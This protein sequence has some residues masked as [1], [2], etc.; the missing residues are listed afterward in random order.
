MAKLCDACDSTLTRVFHAHSQVTADEYQCAV[1]FRHYIGDECQNED[2]INTINNQVY[3]PSIPGVPIQRALVFDKHS[4]NWVRLEADITTP[5]TEVDFAHSCF[6]FLANEL[7]RY[8]AFSRLSED[9]DTR[10]LLVSENTFTLVRSYKH[11][12]LL[13]PLNPFYPGSLEH[14]EPISTYTDPTQ[15]DRQLGELNELDISPAFSDDPPAYL[16]RARAIVAAIILNGEQQRTYRTLL[17]TVSSALL[18]QWESAPRTNVEN[19]V[20]YYLFVFILT[21]LEA[22]KALWLQ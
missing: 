17:L 19:K 12:M 6:Q 7:V 1:C 20:F 5:Y 16:P 22:A 2:E 13:L 8:Y 10:E 15:P 18:A 4:R 14:N 3:L 21:S 9:Q 11:V